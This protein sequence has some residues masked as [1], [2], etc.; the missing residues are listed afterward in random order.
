MKML[1]AAPAALSVRQETMLA[2]VFGHRRFDAGDHNA[3]G[4]GV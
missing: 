3:M 4:Y 1:E 2:S